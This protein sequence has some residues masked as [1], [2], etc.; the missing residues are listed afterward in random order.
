MYLKQECIRMYLK[1]GAVYWDTQFLVLFADIQL[2]SW[3]SQTIQIQVA[4][5]TVGAVL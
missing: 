2:G 3:H 4:T 1:Q 5:N